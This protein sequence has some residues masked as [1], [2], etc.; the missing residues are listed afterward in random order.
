[1][2]VM[3]TTIVIISMIFI[4]ITAEVTTP[5]GTIERLESDTE[6]CYWEHEDNTLYCIQKPNEN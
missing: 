5:V 1:M 2:A 4:A 3:G 6:R